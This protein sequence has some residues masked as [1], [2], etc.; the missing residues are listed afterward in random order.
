M[1]KANKISMV[2]GQDSPWKAQRHDAY[3]PQSLRLKRSNRQ[4]LGDLPGVD[5][6]KDPVLG[7]TVPAEEAV[8]TDWCS[9]CS[10]HVGGAAVAKA[11]NRKSTS[12]SKRRENRT[13]TQPQNAHTAF[14]T[15]S[16]FKGKYKIRRRSL[17]YLKNPFWD[18]TRSRSQIRPDS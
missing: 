4:G 10:P 2:H 5:N 13:P 18:K 11:A 1:K 14:L 15:S 6:D 9:V 12:S 17:L 7:D 8:A 16:Y 3:S